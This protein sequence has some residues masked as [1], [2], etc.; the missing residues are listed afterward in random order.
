M[1]RSFTDLGSLNV[2]FWHNRRMGRTP[3]I[4]DTGRLKLRKDS[5]DVM[6]CSECGGVVEGAGD[7]LGCMPDVCVA[8]SLIE[9]SKS[10]LC[11][12]TG[13]SLE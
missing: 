12:F 13:G 3:Q 6:C 8:S 11:L 4:A 10:D 5:L 1:I 9:A 7:L 2:L